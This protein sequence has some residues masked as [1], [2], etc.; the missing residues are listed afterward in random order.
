MSTTISFI[1]S[2]GKTQAIDL[3]TKII[4]LFVFMKK[5]CDF[6]GQNFCARCVPK[7][8]FNPQRRSCL[9]CLIIIDRESTDEQLQVIATRHLRAYLVHSRILSTNQLRSVLEKQDLIRCI[10]SRKARRVPDRTDVVDQT[11]QVSDDS[12]CFQRRICSID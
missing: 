7:S 4:R 6:C 11:E 10:Q 5:Q 9:I 2:K 1:P 12:L 8:V 3:L